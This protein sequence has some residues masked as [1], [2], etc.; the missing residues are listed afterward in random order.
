[1]ELNGFRVLKKKTCD[2]LGLI[3]ILEAIEKSSN[4]FLIVEASFIVE[5]P[6]VIVSST[7]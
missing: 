1:M 5:Y 4:I 6:I 3:E 7:N 2:L